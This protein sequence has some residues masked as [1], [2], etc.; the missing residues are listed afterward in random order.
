[1]VWDE[2][3]HEAQTWFYPNAGLVRAS[4]K[5]ASRGDGQF[6]STNAE[7][8]PGYQDAK[9]DTIGKSHYKD[10]SLCKLISYF[11]NS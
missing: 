4:S 7:K 10:L 8:E 2:N 6:S 5:P 11:L 3:S 1:V 9:H